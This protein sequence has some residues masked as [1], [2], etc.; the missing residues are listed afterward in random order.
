MKGKF[1]KAL[2]LILPGI[3]LPGF[4]IGTGINAADPGNSRNQ[5]VNIHEDQ[6]SSVSAQETNQS[7]LKDSSYFNFPDYANPQRVGKL[8][9]E[10][11][12]S[13]DYMIRASGLGIHYAELTS[14][15]P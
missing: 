1:A 8:V 7:A 14:S 6:I 11:L 13:R 9:V 4:N 5:Q 10:N 3:F 2:M 15:P 12:L